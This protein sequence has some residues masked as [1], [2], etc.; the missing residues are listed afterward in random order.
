ML[1]KL[2][3]GGDSRRSRLHTEDNHFIGWAASLSEVPT[4]VAQKLSNKLAGKRAIAP[5]W[6]LQ[7]ITKVEAALKP[8]MSAVEFG[9]GSSTLWIAKRV[10]SVLAREHDAKWAAV[11]QKR[12]QDEG[13]DNCE[14]QFRE[15]QHYFDFDPA[16]RF[17][18]A[19]V[20]GQYRWKCIE[21]LGSLMNP[22]GMI[23]FDNSDSDKDALLYEEFGQ[24]GSHLAQLAVKKLSER[25]DVEVEH[26]HSM[27][28]GELFA[29]SGTLISFK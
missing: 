29:G 2:I 16:A 21:V 19:V 4:V 26:I 28:N 15:G 22:G 24:S 9:S 11:T 1:K 6:P 18:F 27:I 12:L 8:A 23:Y 20:D 5:W 14:V 3:S 17:D 13:I 25:D 10:K 7:A